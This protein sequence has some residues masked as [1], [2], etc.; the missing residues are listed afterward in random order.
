MDGRPPVRIDL[1]KGVPGGDF[2]QA[3]KSKVEFEVAGVSLWVVG[4][5]ELI[6]LKHSSGRPQDLVDAARLAEQD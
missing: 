1:M 5:T 6:R 2:D 4:R 3:W